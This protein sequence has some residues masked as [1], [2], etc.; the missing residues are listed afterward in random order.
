[1]TS[2]EAKINIE[3]V[4]AGNLIGQELKIQNEQ[5][6][7]KILKSKVVGVSNDAVIIDR[8]GSSGL[9]NELI[10]NQPV[11]V[12]L[13]Y[14]DEPVSFN[15]RI[16]IPH[17]G[18]MQIPLPAQLIPTIAR[19]FPR[20]PM[21]LNVK[22]ACFSG[23]FIASTRLNKLKWIE[24]TTINI[25]GGGVLVQV[26]SALEEGFFM[27]LHLGL[28]ELELPR[29]VLAR[30]CHCRLSGKFRYMAGVQFIT[31][32]N[33]KDLISRELIRNLPP[34]LFKLDN[35]ARQELAAYLEDNNNMNIL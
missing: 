32:E 17:R 21:V 25:S 30:V 31:R 4:D 26:P 16:I 24:T 23:N 7:G 3:E 18:R 1:M 20:F 14:K 33:Y 22:L 9:V 5:F 12:Y 15:S 28:E 6:P 34:A 13:E 2:E 8:S 29:L 11:I 10:N 35:V 27:I 19:E